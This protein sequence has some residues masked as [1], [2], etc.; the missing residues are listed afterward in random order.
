MGMGLES[1]YQP[2]VNQYNQQVDDDA[3]RRMQ[4]PQY[5]QGQ[6]IGMPHNSHPAQ[7]AGQYPDQMHGN[8]IDPQ[9][10][11]GEQLYQ[12]SHYETAHPGYEA[13]RTYEYSG[14]PVQHQQYYEEQPQSLH[15]GM[16]TLTDGPDGW[17]QPGAEFDHGLERWS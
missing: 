14:Y 13:P 5:A 9:L 12:Y 8:V 4:Y 6:F 10:D 7:L 1:Y 11:G 2:V 3:I 16:A 17:D 15:P